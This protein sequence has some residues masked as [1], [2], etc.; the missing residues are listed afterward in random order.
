[1]ENIATYPQSPGIYAIVN[2]VNG[3]RYVGSSIN[4]RKRLQMHKR[5]LLAGLHHSQILQRAWNKYGATCFFS[6]IIEQCS[7]ESLIE[8]EQI[9]INEKSEYNICGRAYSCL[10]VIRT[11]ETRAKMS[12]SMTG[13]AK[14]L[15]H[16]A[17]LSAAGKGEKHRLFGKHLPE[18][19]R[20]KISVAAIK[21]GRTPEHQEKLNKSRR[22][23][24][25]FLGKT[26]SDETRAKMS[27]SQSGKKHAMYGKHH[28]AE[29]KEK[30]GRAGLGRKHTP[31]SLAKMVANSKHGKPWLGRK[32][33]DETRLK[34]KTAA[35]KLWKERK[36]NISCQA[37]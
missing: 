33:T 31:E 8:H 35:K 5:K 17:N 11:K 34:M 22:E 27:A 15:E 3:K 30:I 10:G 16:R 36:E 25:T 1:M 28:T 9:Y 26:H 29:A 32:H 37:Q 18:S 19:T 13:K 21:R 4:L 23:H 6:T 12:V 7:T 2:S 14:S 20:V 24:P